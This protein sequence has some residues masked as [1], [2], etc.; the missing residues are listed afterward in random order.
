MAGCDLVKL[1]YATPEQFAWA[2]TLLVVCQAQ[3]EAQRHLPIDDD[4]LAVLQTLIERETRLIV[5]LNLAGV[6]VD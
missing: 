5:S 2:L 3:I 4:Q 6:P 1:R